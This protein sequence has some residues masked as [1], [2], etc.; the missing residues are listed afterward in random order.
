MEKTTIMVNGVSI[1]LTV[2]QIARIDKVQRQ[3]YRYRNS[4][5]RMLISL[6]FKQDK[7]YPDSFTHKKEDWYA[8]INDR[9]NWSDCWMTGKGLKESSG[10]PGGWMYDTPMQIKIEVEK[11]NKS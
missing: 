9:G 10:F 1:K 5:K 11:Q 2:Q 4:F 7:E 8:Q 6:G 3:R